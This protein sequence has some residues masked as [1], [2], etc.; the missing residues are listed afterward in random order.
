[1]ILF[2]FGEHWLE[3]R[4]KFQDP[5]LRCILL[6]PPNTSSLGFPAG[7]SVLKVAASL[8]QLL[9]VP[10][11]KFDAPV[12]RSDGLV[13]KF[14]VPV[15]RSLVD[16]SDVH[17]DRFD[18]RV[19]KSD[20]RVDRSDVLVDKSDVHADRSDTLPHDFF[21]HKFCIRFA[22]SFIIRCFRICFLWF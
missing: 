15:D 12:H 11:D 10:V 18:V 2:I 5:M 16:K 22:R 9:S 4:P 7:L 21:V 3:G 1:M 20:V 19:D 17:V 6:P 13:D 14:D 8:P